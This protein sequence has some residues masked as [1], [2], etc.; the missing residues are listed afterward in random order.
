MR[1]HQREN[2]S[3][4]NGP[5]QRAVI[6]TQGCTLACPDCFNPETHLNQSGQDVDVAELVDWLLAQ[7]AELE[8]LTI[9]GGEPFQQPS[10][11]AAL[12][13]AVRSQSHLSILVFTGYT[14]K[15]LL[16][17]PSAAQTLDNI[18][19]LISGRYIASQRVASSLIGSA[20]KT[21]HFLTNRYTIA[22]L[23]TV[24]EAE[25]WINP[26]GSVTFSGIHPLQW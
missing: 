17:I 5:G 7:P 18:D 16:A 15:E 1:I 9:S 23:L 21:A 19:L 26:D 13:T 24:P 10:A 22:D 2:A 8:G 25:I 4:A 14:Q 3:R 20:N 11:L 6:W 12:L